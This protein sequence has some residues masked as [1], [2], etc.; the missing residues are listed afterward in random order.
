M[1]DLF[2]NIYKHGTVNIFF[3]NNSKIR[4]LNKMHYV[5]KFL[6]AFLQT[7]FHPLVNQLKS[8]VNKDFNTHVMYPFCL[9]DKCDWST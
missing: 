3:D 5:L 8:L 6:S 4:P 7:L 1:L 2:E 9:I